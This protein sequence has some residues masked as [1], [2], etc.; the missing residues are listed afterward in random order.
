MKIHKY[1]YLIILLPIAIRAQQANKNPSLPN[2]IL[3]VADDLGWKDLEFMGS[4]YYS[5]PNLNKLARDGMYFT[6]GYASAANCA[7]SRAC[8]MSGL[9]TPR[10]GIYTVASSERG[11]SSNRKLIPTK[12]KVILDEHFPTLPQMLQKAGYFTVNMGKWHLSDNPLPYGFDYNIAGTHQGQPPSYYSPYKIKTLKD[13]EKGEYLTNRLTDEAIKFLKIKKEQPFFLY[14]PHYAVHTPLTAPKEL[15]EKYESKKKSS[16][17]KNAVYAAMIENMD[18]N[19]GRLLNTIDSLDMTKNTLIIF[20]S[21]NGGVRSISSQHPLRA[22]KG[23]YYEGGIRVPMIVRWPGKVKSNTF[24][25]EP[26]TNLDFYPTFLEIA[27]Q[28]YAGK[29]NLDG[30]S[31]LPVF[32]GRKLSERPLYWHFPIYLNEFDSKLDDARDSLF[33]TRP[34]SCMRLGKWKLHQYFEDG[35]FELYNLNKDVG[36]RMNLARSKPKQLAT[37]KNMLKSWQETVKAPIPVELNP[38][39]KE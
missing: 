24:T 23:S 28:T 30:K 11:K 33:R 3:I 17:Q 39:Y 35:E 19:I 9:N 4:H 16:G 8:L 26:V 7:P 22:G 1:L 31:L 21:D 2:I 29:N 10:H 27:A 14:L 36:E 32:A 38:D 18:A 37:L 5:T 12:N 20:T 6:N 13:G 25:N 15:V 34:G